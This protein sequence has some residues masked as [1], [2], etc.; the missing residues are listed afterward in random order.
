VSTKKAYKQGGL[1][2]QLLNSAVVV[3]VDAPTSLKQVD[4][5][6]VN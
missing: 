5:M 4:V 6:P 3:V 2:A 1:L